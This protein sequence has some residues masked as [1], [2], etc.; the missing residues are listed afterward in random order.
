MINK[1]HSRLM[2]LIVINS[3]KYYVKNLYNVSKI[4]YK[5]VYITFT[6]LSLLGTEVSFQSGQDKAIGGMFGFSVDR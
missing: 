4:T 1:S 2:K 3:L 6:R 5:S